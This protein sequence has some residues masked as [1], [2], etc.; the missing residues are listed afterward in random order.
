MATLSV[1]A[2]G[3]DFTNSG[4]TDSKV[5]LIRREQDPNFVVASGQRVSR[6]PMRKP[7]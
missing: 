3:G 6:W 5:E 4:N 7:V 2:V 1:S